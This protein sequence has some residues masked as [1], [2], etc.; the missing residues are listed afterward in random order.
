MLA[1]TFAVNAVVRLL[2]ALI[3]LFSV[4][5]LIRVLG[6]EEYGLWV[7]LTSIIGWLVLLDFG[8]GHALKNTVARAVAN[9]S[10]TLAQ[11]E[12]QQV[13]K[14][15]F[16]IALA[17]V[18]CLCVATYYVDFLKRNKNLIMML[19]LPVLFAF[20]MSMGGM[21][22]Q[23]V[24]RSHV[25]SLIGLLAP[26]ITFFILLYFLV[27]GQSISLQMYAPI[28]AVLLVLTW[29]AYWLVGCAHIKCGKD[30]FL[31]IVSS[32]IRTQ[33]LA[34][35]LRF[36]IL[37]ASSI[38]LYG[39]GSYLIYNYLGAKEAAVY[40]T[41]NKLYFFG[42][43]L[44]N[45]IVAVFWPEITFSAERMQFERVRR[46]YFTMLGLS[47]MFVLGT[48]SVAYFSVDIIYYW[49]AGKITVDNKTPYFFAVLVSVQALAYCGAVV[50]NAVEK[51]TGQLLISIL[52]S[53]AMIPI[54]FVFLSM[55]Y[56]IASVP[57]AASLLTA[58]AMLY[59][60]FSAYFYVRKG[61]KV[62][63]CAS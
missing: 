8:V 10:Y 38:I 1:K 32:K 57:I 41:V 62:T 59:C 63:G 49:T 61:L 16:F 27:C 18:I 23:G 20:P 2:S 53:M 13:F 33:R 25:Q 37:Q 4:P 36:F 29:G 7:T 58:I 42:L 55:D 19:Y 11:A 6:V 9:E 39:A 22:L 44:F 12:A 48:F 56:G 17:V 15:T 47:L 24:R 35:G 3:G 60:N 51:V 26:I 50:L 14:L 40:D 30:F 21:I 54:F 28:Y 5:L 45:M 43:S 34:V 31:G 46:I 52:S